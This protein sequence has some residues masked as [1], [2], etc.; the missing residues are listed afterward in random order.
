MQLSYLPARC[1]CPTDC[2]LITED[3]A[4]LPAHSQLINVHSE[5][6]GNMLLLRRAPRRLKMSLLGLC[7]CCLRACAVVLIT[8]GLDRNT[9]QL[10]LVLGITACS[11]AD[12]A[13]A[14]SMLSKGC[15][16]AGPG[17]Q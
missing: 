1:R 4:E 8:V 9:G 6:L 2:I 3:G 7:M 14:P 16:A 15:T 10:Q 12:S 11:G 17:Q 13:L 5:P